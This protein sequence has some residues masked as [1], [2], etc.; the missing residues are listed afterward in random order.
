MY[1]YVVVSLPLH[2]S[3]ERK[4][5]TSFILHTFFSFWTSGKKS[6]FTFIYIYLFV[7]PNVVIIIKGNFGFNIGGVEISKYPG[8]S[9]DM[10]A[11]IE[12]SDKNNEKILEKKLEKRD[13]NLQNSVEEEP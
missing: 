10:C 4:P 1:L 7:G 13:K 6:L 12:K 8:R 2:G 9:W 11:C 5:Q 3:E